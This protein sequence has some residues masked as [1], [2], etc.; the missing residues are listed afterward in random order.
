MK[1]KQWKIKRQYLHHTKSSMMIK[2]YN[3]KQ[4]L[5][6][7]QLSNHLRNQITLY[8]HLLLKNRFPKMKKK[9]KM[10]IIATVDPNHQ[11]SITRN[12]ILCRWPNEHLPDNNQRRE[13]ENKI[14][15]MNPM[16]M[17]PIQILI[18]ISTHFRK[19]VDCL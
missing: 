15:R 13:V 3:W 18:K 14:E 6:L 8:F 4:C 12:N 10:F 1:K 11:I 5:K 17:L 2:K 7:S 9:T 19:Q 16:K